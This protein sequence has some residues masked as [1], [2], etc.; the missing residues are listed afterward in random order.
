MLLAGNNLMAGSM[1]DVCKVGDVTTPCATKGWGVGVQAL[2]VQPAFNNLNYIGSTTTGT[3]LVSSQENFIDK[4][5]NYEFGFKLEGFYNFGAGNDLNLNWYRYEPTTNKNLPSDINVYDGTFSGNVRLQ[6]KPQWNAVNL[7]YGQRFDINQLTHIR[8]HGGLQYTN[9][10]LTNFTTGSDTTIGN[11]QSRN[12]YSSFQGAGVR[13]G[14]DLSRDLIYGFS[15]YTNLGASLLT[16]PSSFNRQLVTYTTGGTF[17]DA[18]SGSSNIT[19][20][21]LEGKL[22][23]TYAYPLSRGSLM[24]DAAWM[25]INYLDAITIADS[26]HNGRTKESNFAVQGPLFGIRWTGNL[27]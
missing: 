23:F 19:V 26:A 12:N 2:Y 5:F 13:G 10:K 16:G 9:I 21:E 1:G 24:I 11:A 8:L 7:E 17:L 6:L 20:T 15:L 4:D 18:N 27:V 25:W 3:T 14:A 22:G